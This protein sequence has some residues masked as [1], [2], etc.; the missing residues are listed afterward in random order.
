MLTGSPVEAISMPE[1]SMATCPCGSVSTSKIA[2]GLAAIARSTSIRSTMSAI[3][4]P[5]S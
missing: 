4:T 3:I 5:S 2:A 1:L